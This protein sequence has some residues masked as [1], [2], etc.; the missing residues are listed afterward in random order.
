MALLVAALFIVAGCSSPQPSPSS[1]T[2]P[3][4]SEDTSSASADVDG[5]DASETT[6]ELD[7][8]Q[9]EY[10][11]ALSASALVTGFIG[12][13]FYDKPIEN[14]DA[15]L[16]AV[17]SVIERVGGDETTVLELREIRPTETGTTYYTFRQR[18][19]DV[20][21]HGGSVK[22]V[23]DKDHN[24]CGLVSAL[25]P[26]V[27]LED[28]GSWEI[29]AEE[30]EK[31]V[32]DECADSDNVRA[33]L[34]KGATE[35]ALIPLG[36]DTQQ[37]RYAWV[38]YTNNYFA[39]VDTAYLAHYVDADGGYLYAIPVNVPNNADA[40][41]GDEANFPFGELEKA[42]WS[43]TVTKHDGT[44][45][46]INVP[47]LVDPETEEAIL[48]DGDR[49]IVCADYADF[50]FNE[51]ISP[52]NEGEDSFNNDEL[53]IYDTFIKVWDFFESIGWTGPDGE[54]TPTLLGMD[55]VDENDEVIQN[56]AYGG[57]RYGFQTFCFNRI[58]PDGECFDIIAHE[59]THCVTTTTM[60]SNLYLNDAGAINEGMSDIMGNLTEM[61]IA[62]DQD[63]E[64]LI[65]EN[66]GEGVGPYRSM[67]DPH[68]FNQPAFTWDAYYG[69][70][71]GEATTANDCGGVH[72]N[73]SLLNLISYKLDQAGMPL[74]DQMYFWMNVALAMTPSTDY[75]QMAELLPWCMEQAGYTE[76]V[77]A[78]KKAIEDTRIAETEK[79]D[80]IPE[81]LGCVTLSLSENAPDNISEMRLVFKSTEASADAPAAIAWAGGNSDVFM[82]TMP[83][84]DYVFEL[85]RFEGENLVGEFSLTKDGWVETNVEG[86]AQPSLHTVSVASGETVTLPSDGLAA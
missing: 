56:A 67:K 68:A 63:G 66:E 47:I 33:T 13:K 86:D 54:G 83:A 25:L 36:D 57:R 81:G 82:A 71:V 76:Y 34:V 4:A 16:D 35:Q 8:T 37:V 3:P 6:S 7:E 72:V 52:R 17:Q 50:W 28:L 24:A 75:P 21:V 70:A 60:T 53:I 1:E 12:E 39:D 64:W 31:I 46:D 45:M 40:L 58:D 29:S 32:L 15:A 84:G 9:A 73:S 41:A 2:T 48:A 20:L 80:K 44:K 79:P 59:F 38:V 65:G 42:T 62:Y 23:V 85:K 22:L 11:R 78:L 51:Q 74:T 5:E 55:M 61:M 49:K 77:D 10:E 14:D 43:G 69:P 27:Q 18:A 26:D 19:G 30:A